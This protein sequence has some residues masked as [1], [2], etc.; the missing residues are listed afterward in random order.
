[1]DAKK[2]GK[3][4]KQGAGVRGQAAGVRSQARLD[5]V[6]EMFD[7]LGQRRLD[8]YR[9]AQDVALSWFSKCK[10]GPNDFSGAKRQIDDLMLRHATLLEAQKIIEEVSL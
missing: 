5:T 10:D 1:M 7:R 8:V 9:N 4:R 2:K 3:G 6:L